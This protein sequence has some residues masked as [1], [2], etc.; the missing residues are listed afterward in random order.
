MGEPG[1][2]VVMLVSLSK[3]AGVSASRER[4]SAWC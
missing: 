1:G 4:E 2:R 3:G